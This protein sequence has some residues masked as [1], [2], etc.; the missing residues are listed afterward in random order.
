MFLVNPDHAVVTI[1]SI[2]LDQKHDYINER[3]TR[4]MKDPSG[5]QKNVEEQQQQNTAQRIHKENFF[6]NLSNDRASSYAFN[7][8]TNLKNRTK[9]NK[10]FQISLIETSFLHKPKESYLIQEWTIEKLPST[11]THC[12]P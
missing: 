12:K 4:T 1:F 10:I 3:I 7:L 6:L 11:C 9:Q 8:A 5:N 2:S